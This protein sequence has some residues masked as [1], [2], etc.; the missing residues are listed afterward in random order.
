ML[1]LLAA[2]S[3]YIA[4]GA[5]IAP[6]CSRSSVTMIGA[7]PIIDDDRRNRSPGLERNFYDISTVDFKR[8]YGGGGGGYG[9]GGYSGG[10]F[11]GGGG[12]SMTSSFG[13]GGGGS[14]MSDG[15]GYY[16]G[17]GMDRGYDRA[18]GG[19]GMDHG[20]YGG[21]Y[22]GSY[23]GGYGGGHMG[24]GMGRGMNRGYGGRGMSRRSGTGYNDGYSR[25]LWQS[26]YY[27]GGAYLG[28]P[29]RVK[30]AESRRER[31]YRG[32]TP[33][34]RGRRGGYGDEMMMDR[35]YEDDCFHDDY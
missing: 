12:G 32:F 22:G 23:G 33:W 15:N 10:S 7:A 13:G 20:G 18:Y 26:G 30:D 3:T 19:R 6:V 5:L 29:D 28:D 17:R 21:G 14:M 24:R 2:S 4:P 25:D 8:P 31:R 9:G 35:C 27:G 11:G 1:A 16:G 34:A